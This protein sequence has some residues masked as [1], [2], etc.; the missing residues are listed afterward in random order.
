[1]SK[2]KK[3]TEVSLTNKLQDV[4]ERI[5]GAEDKVDEMNN[6]VKEIVKFKKSTGVKHPG[7]LGCQKRQAHG[8]SL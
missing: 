5:S 6:S 7:N 8:S 1:M 3:P 4:E 2:K